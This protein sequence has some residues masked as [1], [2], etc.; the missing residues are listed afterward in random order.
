MARTV[1]LLKYTKWK[2]GRLERAVIDFLRWRKHDRKATFKEI[3]EKFAGYD[4]KRGWGV[5]EAVLRL[6]RRRIVAVD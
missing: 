3:R 6:S 1:R 2:C 4:N 5:Y